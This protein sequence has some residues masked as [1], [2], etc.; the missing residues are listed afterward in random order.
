MSDFRM[1]SGFE[2]VWRPLA[3]P[4]R[5]P[6]RVLKSNGQGE[7][8][9]RLGRVVRGA[10]EVMVKITGRTHSHRQLKAHL[11]Y[12]TRNGALELEDDRGWRLNGRAEIAELA[13][14]WS[15]QAELD[16]SR[17]SDAPLS[18][19]LILSMPAGTDRTA[20]HVAGRRFAAEALGD[21]FEFVFLQ[22]SDT[23]HPHLHLTVR[24][25]G[26]YG[27]RLNLLHGDLDQWRQ[28]FARALRE[29]GVEAEATPRRARGVT[30]RSESM[31]LRKLAER[32]PGVEPAQTVKAAMREAALAA[33]GHDRKLRPWEE[34]MDQRQTLIRKTYLAQASLLARSENAT[35]R[36]M[37]R[38]IEKFVR[39]MPAPDSR[40]LALA[41]FLRD[42]EQR[43]RIVAPKERD[44]TR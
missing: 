44:R 24:S 28:G 38:Q 5:T 14:D 2:D 18:H 4:R 35:D 16:R 13:A 32:G 30:R 21:R 36:A 6:A 41:R 34:A 17:R 29:L 7:A 23:D 31:V 20:L 39:N 25:C 37:A 15:V 8:G 27:E 40:R 1:I 22:H 19:S 26:V 33:F 12:I 10:P 42:Q 9:V 3:L 11:T 43:A